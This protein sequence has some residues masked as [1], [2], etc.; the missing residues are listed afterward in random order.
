MLIWI[1]ILLLALIGALFVL[2]EYATRVSYNYPRYTNR[3][4]VYGKL[5]GP[6]P[7]DPAPD[8]E[9]QDTE[10]NRVRL[11]DFS[12][13]IVVLTTGSGSCPMYACTQTDFN[14]LAQR[15]SDDAV[16]INLYV[17]EAHPGDDFPH[18][19]T[20]EQ[21]VEHARLT[22]SEEEDDRLMLVDGLD[23]AI[24][25]QYGTWPNMAYIIDK[26][27]IVR[28]KHKW[29]DPAAVE[30]ALDR[31][32]KGEP[33][34]DIRYE[35]RKPPETLTKRI[36]ARACKGAVSD[37]VLSMPGLPYHMWDAKHSQE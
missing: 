20:L 22:K 18:H 28:L 7:G 12:G 33:I 19:E 10:G 31:L 15:Y 32:Q 2:R 17:R 35:F 23:G 27:G 25:T 36:F 24:H 16:F 37:F 11:S 14:A 13:K 21:K 1:P 6:K 34:D 30:L 8:F 3:Q 29:A 4:Y 5:K 9:A 26:D